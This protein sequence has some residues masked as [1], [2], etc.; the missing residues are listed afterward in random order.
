MLCEAALTDEIG[1]HQSQRGGVRPAGGTCAWG[2]DA[3]GLVGAGGA[4]VGTGRGRIKLW[5]GFRRGGVS[6]GS[7]VAVASLEPAL[8]F[9]DGRTG[10]GA[11]ILSF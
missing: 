11:V 2:R 9:G 8:P 1:C 6:G 7:G 3:A 5:P 4:A 10:S